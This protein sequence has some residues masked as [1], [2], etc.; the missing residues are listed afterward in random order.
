MV[1]R[2]VLAFSQEKTAEKIKNMLYGTGYEAEMVC[3]TKAELIRYISKIDDVLV[4]MGYKLPDAVADSVY[5]DMRPG[6]KLMAIVKADRQGSIENPDI[7]TV[8]LPVSRQRLISSIEVFLGV[9]EKR[10]KNTGRAPEED[11]IINRAK[12]YLMETYMMTEEQAHRFIQKRSMDT[13]ARFID[14]A[15]SILN[16]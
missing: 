12:L 1:E 2:V 8:P 13:G 11:K 3:R 10:S 14:T 9:I 15:R 6:Q 7:L 5:E 16:I 4:I